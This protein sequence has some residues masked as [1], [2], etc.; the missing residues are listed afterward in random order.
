ME[1]I[2][3][4][5]WRLIR[6]NNGEWISDRNAVLLSK[7]EIDILKIVATKE[8]KDLHV[9]LGPYGTFWCYKHEMVVFDECSGQT[10]YKPRKLKI[11]KNIRYE[12][13]KNE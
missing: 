11:T 13:T 1:S 9:Q 3:E 4:S 7:F 2:E 12:Q 5:G 8:G 6:N 10:E